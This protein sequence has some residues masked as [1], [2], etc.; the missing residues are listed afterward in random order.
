MSPARFFHAVANA[1]RRLRADRRGNVLMMTAFA[2]LPL[3]FAVGF[4]IDY[5]RASRFQTKLNAAADAAALAAVTP[6]AITQSDSVAQSAALA[7]FDTQ[8]AGM[9]GLTVTSRSAS[10]SS[11]ASGSLGTLRTVV[12]TYTATSTNIFASFLKVATL[13]ISGSATASASQ[14]P[15]INFYIA[16]DVSPSM[17]IATT[18]D[19]IANL[20][21]GVWWRGEQYYYSRQ[22]GCDFACH[23]NNAH[24]WNAGIYVIDRS[25]R[26]ILLSGTTIYRLDCSTGYVYNAAVSQIGNT[27][28]VGTGTGGTF[29]SASDYCSGY[30]P[31]ANPVTLRYKA[32]GSSSYTYVSVNFPD[33]W[34]LAQNYGTV[35]SG[36][37]D[38]T[39]RTDAE[40]AAAAGVIQYAYNLE[41]QYATANVPPVY[42]MQFFTFAYGNPAALGTSPFGTMTDVA[43]S[44]SSTF[45]DLGA[46]APLLAA[47]SYWTSLTQLTNNADTDVSAMLT[48]MKSTMPTASGTGTPTSPQSVLIVITDGAADSATDGMSSF[49]ATNLSQCTAIKNTGA[50]IAIL[51]TE[52]KPETINYTGHPTFNSFA[53][54]QVPSIASQ[55]QACASR[56]ADG[57]YLM[58]TVSTDGSVSAALN[59]LFAMT[60]QTAKLIQ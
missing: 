43:T 9:S 55:L 22:D 39:L 40:S 33:S 48:G 41:R 54:N 24:Q 2:L 20:K 1:F 17:L 32:T 59:T 23:S 34:W 31:P 3:T 11:V 38:I 50:R 42:K 18:T 57:T 45:P 37:S 13:P 12:V 60:V 53:T 28:D 5:A 52:Y 46:A 29:T 15:S 47:N 4:G 14:P 26:E 56:N 25:S 27:G 6:Q 21:A 16:L 19:G 49:T 30:S 35:N 36:Y 8:A 44:Y 58:Q 51:Y 7:I 10:V